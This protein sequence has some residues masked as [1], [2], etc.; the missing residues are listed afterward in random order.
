MLTAMYA[1]SE[2]LPIIVVAPRICARLP[3][4]VFL[5]HYTYYSARHLATQYMPTRSCCH[6]CTY[7]QRRE[8]LYYA[9]LQTLLICATC[10][11]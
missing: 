10:N 1:V 3:I 6:F 4:L 7:L 2:A 5:K 9:Q 8:R 11:G